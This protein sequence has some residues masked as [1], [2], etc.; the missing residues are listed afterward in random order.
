MAVWGVYSVHEQAGGKRI[1]PLPGLKPDQF[2]IFKQDDDD[3]VSRT[4]HCTLENHGLKSDF[5]VTVTTSANPAPVL[6]CPPVG[7]QP[8]L[9]GLGSTGSEDGGKVVCL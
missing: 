2:Y 5:G 7:M 4:M 3:V 6:L 9:Q 1:H 8:C